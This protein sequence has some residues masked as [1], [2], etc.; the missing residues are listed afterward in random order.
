MEWLGKVWRRVRG[1]GDSG[2]GKR[3]KVL[4]RSGSVTLE[5]RQE[6]ARGLFDAAQAAGM[7]GFYL[8][9]D[10]LGGYLNQVERR[11]GSRE[12]ELSGQLLWQVMG[13]GRVQIASVIPRK[14]ADSQTYLDSLIDY[15]T[16][17]TERANLITLCRKVASYEGIVAT[18][19]DVLSELISMNGYTLGGADGNEEAKMLCKAWLERVNGFPRKSS[20]EDAG[21]IRSWS[22]LA[23]LAELR[24]GDYVGLEKWENVE[25]PELGASYKL[26][27]EIENFNV[28]S[29]E[30]PDDLKAIKKKIFFVDL[31]Q[32]VTR[33]ASGSGGASSDPKQKLIDQ[34]LKESVSPDLLKNLKAYKDKPPLPALLTVHF[35]R[36]SDGSDWGQPWVQKTF[37]ALAYKNRIRQLDNATI[38]G[39]VQ[40]VWVLKL[41]SDDPNSE[42]HLV[43]PERFT[44]AINTFK[45]LK[46]QNIA[47]WPGPDLDT[48]ELASS[49]SNILSFDGRYKEADADIS[50]AMGVPMILIDGSQG[51][52][53][54]WLMFI[55]TLALL[56]GMAER[57]AK[58]VTKTLRKIVMEN[59]IDD[60]FPEFTWNMLE[61]RD[62]QGLRS[63]AERLYELG[64]QG[65]RDTQRDL[66]KDPDKTIENMIREK[67]ENLVS[68]L[69][70]PRIP[71]QGDRGRP[72]NTPDG[73]GR[74]KDN[75]APEGKED[76]RNQG[77]S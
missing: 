40:R 22:K 3:G 34:T 68:Q 36:N 23:A 47:I 39:L 14:M 29:L 16:K 61:I 74:G 44:L 65:I 33:L 4:N 20:V 25:I 67:E 17:L 52:K 57:Q 59:G 64:L 8:N 53:S 28:V 6:I 51:A 31:P 18:A 19:L 42:Y 27:V 9:P 70:E 11:M 63:L 69:P 55:P 38:A 35:S 75:D 41:G 12:P 71:Y 21:G 73:G 72:G 62:R 43:S 45:N 54:D 49:D 76:T 30:W 24:D 50:R 7:E 15:N 77:N 26:P 5:A 37:A 56:E 46:A 58:Y 1:R 10:G 48:V 60:V 13:D 2:G 32:A 66:G